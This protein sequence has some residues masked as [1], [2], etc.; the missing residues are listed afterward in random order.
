M[1]DSAKLTLFSFRAPRE[2]ALR[3]LFVY[4]FALYTRADDRREDAG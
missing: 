1:P 4:L 2:I 3:S